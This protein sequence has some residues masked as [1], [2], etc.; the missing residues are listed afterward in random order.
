MLRD[1]AEKYFI[2]QDFNC[3]ETA[4]RAIRDEYSLDIAEDDLK[5]VSAFGGGMGCG[6]TCGV[7]CGCLAAYGKMNVKN[8]AHEDKSFAVRCKTFC[9]LFNKKL[10]NTQCSELKIVYRNDKTRCLKTVELGLEA[11]EEFIES[12]KK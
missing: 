2:E 4:L 9:E 3:A 10:G 11:F 6:K 8:R 12:Q 7:L 5:L 1:R